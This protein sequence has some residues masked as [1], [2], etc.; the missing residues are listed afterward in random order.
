[1]LWTSR[2]AAVDFALLQSLKNMGFAGVE[3]PLLEG[4][5]PDFRRLKAMIDDLGLGVTASSALT[6]LTNPISAEPATRRAAVDRLKWAIDRCADLGAEILCGPLHSAIGCFSGRGP[7]RDEFQRGVESLRE[8]AVYAASARVELA[9]EYLNRFENYFLTTAS[10]ALTFVEAVD[11]P[12]CGMMWD[13]FHAHI[14]EKH[15]STT[16]AAIRRKL[17]HVH[18]SENDRGVPGSGQV[19]WT[20]TFQ[21][22]RRSNY[23][24]WLVIEAFGSS[25]PELAAATCVWRSLFESEDDL[26][27]RGLQFI[28][29]QWAAAMP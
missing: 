2:V 15:S 1:M 9:I 8:A 17:I 18:V 7:T 11:H 12:S 25:L 29:K 22:L 23:D 19:R 21:T 4:K 13:T 26:C 27:R 20:E 6:S 28:E 5:P 14:E 3:I 16:I 10:D 24:R